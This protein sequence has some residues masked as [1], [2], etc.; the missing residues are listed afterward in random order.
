[1]ASTQE[2]KKSARYFFDR[3]K[4]QKMKTAHFFLVSFY[5]HV[6]YLFSTLVFAQA[7]GEWRVVRHDMEWVWK[8]G[9]VSSARTPS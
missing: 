3:A 2:T 7:R 8:A 5:Y 4:Y 6:E 1:L 9:H